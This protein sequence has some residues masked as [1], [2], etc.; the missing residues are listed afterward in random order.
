M[1]KEKLCHFQFHFQQLETELARCQSELEA[2]N[3]HARVADT[4]TEQMA[5][6]KEELEKKLFEKDATIQ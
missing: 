3:A 5:R 2:E 4:A 1:H 6:S